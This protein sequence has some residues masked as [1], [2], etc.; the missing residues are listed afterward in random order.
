MS[1]LYVGGDDG[2]TI[3]VTSTSQATQIANNAYTTMC[4]DIV[5]QNIG[6]NP[7][8]IKSGG[9][10]AVASALSIMVPAQWRETFRKG[11]GATHLAAICDAGKTTTLVVFCVPEES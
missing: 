5:V 6:D 3:A 1:E 7:V 10:S 8:Y 4:E 11:S 2:I 9:A